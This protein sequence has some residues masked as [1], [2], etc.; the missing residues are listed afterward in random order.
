MYHLYVPVPTHYCVVLLRD[1]LSAPSLNTRQQEINQVLDY[2]S[3]PLAVSSGDTHDLCNE[4]QPRFIRREP[5][6]VNCLIYLFANAAVQ[7][8]VH[9]DI[10]LV[11]LTAYCFYNGV[12]IS[13]VTLLGHVKTY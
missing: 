11:D 4:T 7:N 3:R 10:Y 8:S 12:G 9:G 2:F 13:D 1:T 5:V 6:C